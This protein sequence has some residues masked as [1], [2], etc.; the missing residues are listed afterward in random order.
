MDHERVA[1]EIGGKQTPWAEWSGEQEFK[2]ATELP[3]R[4]LSNG[5]Q[6]LAA[7]GSAFSFIP[8]IMHSALST[9][10]P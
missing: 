10:I 4:N 7:Q 5:A 8:W 9:D 6:R 1:W 3:H 2:W